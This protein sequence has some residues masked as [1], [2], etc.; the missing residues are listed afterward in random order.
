M[1]KLI[2][3]GISTTA[4]TIYHFVCRYR[5]FDVAGFAV[6]KEYIQ[7]E[8]FLGKP[9]YALEDLDSIIDIKKDYVFVSM[10][11]NRLNADR[12]KVYET[13]KK[14]GYRF[15]NI[16]S[17]KAHVFGPL[18]GE[19]C[20]IADMACIEYHVTIGNNVFVKGSAFIGTHAVISDHCFIGA[21]STIGGAV[22]IGE[23]SFVGMAAV[24]FDDV[25]V[26]KK[27][28]VGASTTLKRNLPDYSVYK[29]SLN[30]FVEKNYSE[31]EIEAKLM[32]NKNVR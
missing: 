1:D 16:I 30:A 6:N 31:D 9:I 26:G 27:C 3:V 19:N 13:L 15:A 21:H 20:W 4:E 32:F 24:V 10:Q 8:S 11:W 22:L 25:K 18:Q 17:P 23:Q 29:S 5:L 2:I 28:I 12:R 7:S 14:K